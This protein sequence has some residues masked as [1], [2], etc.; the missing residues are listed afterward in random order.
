[1]VPLSSTVHREQ[2]LLMQLEG[3]GYTVSMGGDLVEVGWLQQVM[4]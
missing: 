4:L 1:M 2:L 3:N